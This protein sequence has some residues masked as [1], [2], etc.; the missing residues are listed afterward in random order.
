[1]KCPRFIFAYCIQIIL[2]SRH[3]NRLKNMSANMY[4][5]NLSEI[6][7]FSVKT[8]SAVNSEFCFVDGECQQSSTLLNQT[9]TLDELSCLSFCKKIEGCSHF[10][11]YAR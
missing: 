10:S 1:M 4:G 7:F 5:L 6:D 9:V 3:E 8:E 2:I 11:F